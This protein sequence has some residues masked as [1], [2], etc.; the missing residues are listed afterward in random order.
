MWGSLSRQE[1]ESGFQA[2]AKLEE[3]KPTAVWW[4]VTVINCG[5]NHTRVFLF[6]QQ[7]QAAGDVSGLC[8]Q[9]P[10]LI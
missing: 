1:C 7:V 6:K 10:A 4:N 9:Q 3:I 5:K 2:N 8:D